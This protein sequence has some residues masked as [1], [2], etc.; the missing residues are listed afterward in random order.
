MGRRL[1]LVAQGRDGADAVG[2]GQASR[3]AE[4]NM[5]GEMNDKVAIVTGGASGLGRATVELFVAEGAKVVIADVNA[6]AGEALAK[7]LG[8]AAAFK[9]TDVSSAEEQN[10]L[11][12]FAVAQ[13][14]KLDVM[15]N[16]AAISC[17]MHPNF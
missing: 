10:A 11:I 8:P 17:V 4:D 13:F 9:K 5:A 14:G 3:L 1:W 7:A 6:E 2:Y 12:A 15:F 16:N